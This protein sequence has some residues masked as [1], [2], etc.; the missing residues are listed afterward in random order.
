M[1]QQFTIRKLVVI[2]GSSG[3]GRPS[4]GRVSVPTRDC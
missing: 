1:A 4:Q 2:G 3:M